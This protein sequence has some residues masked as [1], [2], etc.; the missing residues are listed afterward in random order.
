MLIA[1]IA[2]ALVLGVVAGYTLR[3]R[4]EL[5]HHKDEIAD[6][7]DFVERQQVELSKTRDKNAI[8]ERENVNLAHL[9]R[10][11]E[12]NL[13]MLLSEMEKSA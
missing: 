13:E 4:Q 10:A 7:N 3:L 8:L 2:L 1:L 5:R 9:N 12:S 6:L 11:H